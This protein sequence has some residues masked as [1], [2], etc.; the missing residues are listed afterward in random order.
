M[1]GFTSQPGHA[2]QM[3]GRLHFFQ[4]SS[5]LAAKTWPKCSL[6]SEPAM[7]QVIGEESTQSLPTPLCG[8]EL[9]IQPLKPDL[10]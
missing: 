5:Q 3:D 6:H 4:T 10:S 1:Q 7:S 2:E 8:G 9:L